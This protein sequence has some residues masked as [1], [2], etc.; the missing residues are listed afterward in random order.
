M[1]VNFCQR[2]VTTQYSWSRRRQ[3]KSITSRSL[4][5][6]APSANLPDE[7]L[8]RGILAELLRMR[9]AP[10]LAVVGND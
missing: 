2:S 10:R 1:F 9:A 3:L 4:P 8:T 5:I 7:A 6:A